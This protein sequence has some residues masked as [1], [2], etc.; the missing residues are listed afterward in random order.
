MPVIKLMRMSFEN[1]VN[2]SL[3]NKA[4]LKMGDLAALAG[5]YTRAIEA[6]EQ[7]A[8]ASLNSNLTK[9]SVKDYYLKSG[10]CFLANKV[11][12]SLY[13]F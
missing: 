11:G 9:W 8:L 5:Q 4:K 3:A 10:A 13:R 7:V 6:Y 1:G 12:P 2:G